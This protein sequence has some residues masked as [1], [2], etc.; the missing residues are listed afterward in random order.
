MLK[1]LGRKRL[2]IYFIVFISIVGFGLLLVARFS[3]TNI[4]PA[5]SSV[6]DSAQKSQAE[7]MQPTDKPEIAQTDLIEVQPSEA[8]TSAEEAMPGQN[9]PG[10]L[11]ACQKM[12]QMYSSDHNTKIQ[13]ESNR[14]AKAQQDIIN[15]YS[16]EGRSFSPAE[17]N[18]QSREQN[19][20]DWLVKQID[21]QYQKQL[22]GLS[23]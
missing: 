8:V 4:T 10:Y 12:K 3:A 21:G 22:H 7:P 14:F 23:C 5:S 6:Q 16:K 17:K 9:A 2:N 1:G 19:R 11:T 18:A 13:S 15:K 20:H